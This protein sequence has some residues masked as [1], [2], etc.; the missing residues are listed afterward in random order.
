MT[1]QSFRE[2]LISKKID[3]EKFAREEP[4]Q[5]EEHKLLF[6]Q[7]HPNSYTA[8]KKFLINDWR[9]KYPYVEEATQGK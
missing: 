3:S 4:E 8:Q 1:T 6:E 5:W 7:I 9:K 2:Y